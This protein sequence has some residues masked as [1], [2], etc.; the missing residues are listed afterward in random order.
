M[1]FPKLNFIYKYKEDGNAYIMRNAILFVFALF[2]L[3]S[4]AITALLH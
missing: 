2:Y 1:T 4:S 3:K